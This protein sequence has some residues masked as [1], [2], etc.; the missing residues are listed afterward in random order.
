M[1]CKNCGAPMDENAAVCIK[2]GV[3]KGGGTSFC[4]N[5][6]NATA[7]GAAV[8]LNCGVS[9][10]TAGTQ[11]GDKSKMAAGLLAIFLGT[12][13]VHNFYLGFTTK[14][15]IQLVVS[16]VGGAVTCG[17]A[18][19][20]IWVWALVEGIMILTGKINTDAKGYL[21]RD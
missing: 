18:T 8:C 14:A 3:Q 15:V 4:P 5:C 20:G 2:C 6:G 21:L 9:L 1:F 11:V 7:P 13:G 19:I 12:F 17:I 10:A 16:L